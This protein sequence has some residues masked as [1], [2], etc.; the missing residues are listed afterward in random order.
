VQRASTHLDPSSDGAEVAPVAEPQP[1]GEVPLLG[2]DPSPNAY[3]PPHPL[4]TRSHVEDAAPVTTPG[5]PVPKAHP[6][7]Q[8]AT[9]GP[10]LGLGPPLTAA[11]R[12]AV[13]TPPTPYDER[14]ASGP[15]PAGDGGFTEIAIQR[16]PP[17]PAPHPTA[18]SIGQSTGPT[19]P[20][21]PPTDDVGAGPGERPV[22]VAPPAPQP[23]PGLHLARSV[24]L[25]GPDRA[26]TETMSEPTR[27]AVTE[28]GEADGTAPVEERTTTSATLEEATASAVIATD[29]GPPPDPP[30]VVEAPAVLSSAP[31]PLA[32]GITTSIQRSSALTG[33]GVPSPSLVVRPAAVVPPRASGERAVRVQRVHAEQPPTSPALPRPSSGSPSRGAS[34]LAS[35]ASGSSGGVPA[36]RPPED[37]GAARVQRWTGPVPG[38]APAAPF[39]APPLAPTA[40]QVLSPMD[41]PLV[42]DDGTWDGTAGHEPGETSPDLHAP[43]ARP[44]PVVSRAIEPPA[45]PVRPFTASP[46]SQPTRV[47]APSLPLVPAVGP[48]VQAAADESADGPSPEPPTAGTNGASQVVVQTAE[49]L[50]PATPPAT[51]SGSGTPGA[52]GGAGAGGA[53]SA[54]GD[55]DALAQRLFPSLVRR[56][57]AEFLLDR[58]RRG[59]RTDPW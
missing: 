18:Q 52:A 4:G 22:T 26:D 27:P 20:G 3:I 6:V 32:A 24:D 16:S 8:R 33:P 10:R 17:V 1:D 45:P 2:A 43:H 29:P 35:P 59:S 53:A 15:M 38:T 21:G 23:A 56:M 58:E 12:T 51:T 5:P 19:R 40:V 13:P 44:T 50:P 37:R 14:A 31:L 48:V 36:G 34:T 54:T 39:T 9:N 7:V 49:A 25:A 41:V 46:R 55:V 30:A 28:P 11:P 42:V 47:A 57:K